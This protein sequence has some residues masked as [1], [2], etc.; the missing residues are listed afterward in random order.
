MILSRMPLF[1]PLQLCPCLFS[2]A[3]AEKKGPFHEEE[4]FM[5]VRLILHRNVKQS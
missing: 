4:E 2:Q 3:S 1:S 5:R